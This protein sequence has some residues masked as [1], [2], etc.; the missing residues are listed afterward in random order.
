M[1]EPAIR[2]GRADD[3]GAIADLQTRAWA[4]AYRGIIPDH[5]LDDPG[6]DAERRRR[7]RTWLERPDA[8]LLVGERS[9]QLVGW[10]RFDSERK[11]D[12]VPGAEIHG[13]YVDPPAWRTGVGRALLAAAVDQLAAA[14]QRSVYL[15]TLEAA[16]AA[17]DFYAAVGFEPTGARHVR[18]FA[19]GVSAP[20]VEYRLRLAV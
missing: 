20:E 13:L 14:G 6:V 11:A 17:R 15:W 4:A 7:W 12:G 1:S 9:G 19:P 5:F 16:G 18:T 2:P 10:I 8:G 3:A